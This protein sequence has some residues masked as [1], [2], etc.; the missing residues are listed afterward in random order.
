MDGPGGQ[1][2]QVIDPMMGHGGDGGGD[3]GIRI[4]ACI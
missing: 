4:H 2:R 3:Q 1:G